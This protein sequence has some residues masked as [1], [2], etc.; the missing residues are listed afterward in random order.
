[1]KG[2]ILSIISD[3]SYSGCWVKDCMEFLDEQGV[4]PCGHKAREKGMVVKVL[5]SCKSNETPTE[6]RYSVNGV[7]ND[8]N[9]GGIR[10]R[11][12]TKLLETQ[13]MDDIDSSH[14]H[15]DN[16]TIK[17]S[18]TLQSNYTWQNFVT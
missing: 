12:S 8:I 5:S 17:E 6:Y 9:T 10:I 14:L 2:R 4:Q 1:M 13:T 15:C 11:K 18:C 3:C 16:K 7:C